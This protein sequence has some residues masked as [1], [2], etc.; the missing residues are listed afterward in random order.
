MYCAR[1]GETHTLKRSLRLK[2]ASLL[3]QTGLIKNISANIEIQQ[4]TTPPDLCMDFQV[5]MPKGWNIHDAVRFEYSPMYQRWCLPI[6]TAA[7]NT[8]GCQLRSVTEQPKYLTANPT[9]YPGSFPHAGG[10]EFL[11]FTED[12]LSASRVTTLY[13]TGCALMG[14]HKSPEDLQKLLNDFGCTSRTH[15]L[16]WLDPDAPGVT[17]SRKLQK[18]LELLGCTGVTRVISSCDPKYLTRAQI[19][20]TLFQEGMM[21]ARPNTITSIEEQARLSST[22]S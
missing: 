6:R 19:L 14:T 4:W 9:N 13:S 17:A 10:Y 3:K 5:P 21:N 11:I 2:T 18:T 7:G 16:I 15:V 1:C 22:S 20:E 12:I 8:V